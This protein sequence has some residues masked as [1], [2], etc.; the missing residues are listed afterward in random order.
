M[1]EL[2]IIGGGPAGMTAAVYAARKHLDMVMVSPEVGG[3]AAWAPNVEN[4][5]GF[6]MI[7]G[8]ELVDRFREHV[9]EFGVKTVDARVER[10]RLID[11]AFSA[12]LS[13]GEMVDSTAVVVASGRSAKHLGVPGE[14]KYRGK[15][16]AYCATC[17]A[18]LFAGEDVVV[19]GGGNSGVS[20]AIQLSKIARKVYLLEFRDRLMSDQVLK[21]RVVSAEN[22]TIYAGHRVTEIGGGKMVEYVTIESPQGGESL[23][24]P[25]AGVFVEIGSAP[26]IGFLPN[27]LAMTDYGEIIIDCG[28]R[29]NIP[30]LFAAGDATTVPHKQIIVAAGE[31]AKGVLSAYDYLIRG[32]A[33]D[34]RESRAA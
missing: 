28:N 6:T 18:P 5:L 23:R 34:Y 30:G 25:V 13:N 11:G 17:D 33:A 14:A 29:T 1:H 27:E 24:L 19:V 15:G 9:Q 26:N 2:L 16:V 10:L 31:G 7:T 8:A 32:C 21:D 4:Y 22:V 20:A 12:R 3:Q